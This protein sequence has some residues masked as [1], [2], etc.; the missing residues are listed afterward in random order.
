VSR[1]K[2]IE[3]H[4]AMAES[5]IVETE[6]H[7]AHQRRIVAELERHGRGHSQTAKVAK[8]ILKSFE[9]AQKA[10]FTHRNS[11]KKALRTIADSAQISANLPLPPASSSEHL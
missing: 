9:I 1:H 3:T 2:Q 4:L 11:L 10:N 8:E 7:L 5:H 6:S